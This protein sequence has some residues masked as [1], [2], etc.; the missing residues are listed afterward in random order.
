[1]AHGLRQFFLGRT[2]DWGDAP[3]ALGMEVTK[4]GQLRGL[5]NDAV[6]IRGYHAHETVWLGYEEEDG[7]EAYDYRHYTELYAIL[8]PPLRCGLRVDS[9]KLAPDAP[10]QEDAFSLGDTEL[11]RC[12]QGEASQ[13]EIARA[14]LTDPTVR[15]LLLEHAKTWAKL[16]VSD[17]YVTI[18]LPSYERRL[19]YVKPALAAVGAIGEAV[20]RARAA[21]R[22][23]AE[24]AQRA[25]WAQVASGWGLDLSG[26]GARMQ[27]AVRGTALDVRL[28]PD[29]WGMEIAV[30]LQT[31][32]PCE[33]RLRRQ[34]PEDKP[35]GDGL[36]HQ[37]FGFQDIVVGDPAF[38][39]RFIVQGE[40]EDAVRALLRPEARAVLLEV[41][42]R[43]PGMKLEDGRLVV[44]EKALDDPRELDQVLKLCFAAAEA[45][46]P[47]S[48][49][50]DQG[51]FRACSGRRRPSF[52]RAGEE[53]A[54]STP[55]RAD[56]RR[57][58]TRWHGDR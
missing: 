9:W 33:L 48:A 36:I 20:L 4:G 51:P 47:P 38:D 7:S 19:R 30:R 39:A 2:D 40:P 46:S 53:T 31:P 41:L 42:D 11:D 57:R 5:W 3:R 32:P 22:T 58:T 45:L 35:F 49:S 28:S 21:I 25:A 1:M 14:V 56:A 18:E 52:G 17:R 44:L 24:E 50:P 27:G 6:E 26:D 10:R 16:W 13:R 55:Q 37:V 12:Y 23:P 8:E 54:A 29:G 15:A 34:A 43:F